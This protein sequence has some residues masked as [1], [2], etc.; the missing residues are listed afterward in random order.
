MR[1]RLRTRL[2]TARTRLVLKP[3]TPASL[4]LE[5]RFHGERAECR[6]ESLL[7]P[8]WQYVLCVA[9]VVPILIWLAKPGRL[10]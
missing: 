10:L 7:M 3:P 6:S 1:G 2:A 8:W 9:V 5:G 4:T